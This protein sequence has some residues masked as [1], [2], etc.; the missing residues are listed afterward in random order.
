MRA[1]LKAVLAFLR[2]R[3][4]AAPSGNEALQSV[5]QKLSRSVAVQRR[6]LTYL[7]TVAATSGDPEKAALLANEVARAYIDAQVRAKIDSALAAA[8]RRQRGHHPV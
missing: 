5:L 4:D 2:L 6:G 3:D 1:G 7:V 8:D